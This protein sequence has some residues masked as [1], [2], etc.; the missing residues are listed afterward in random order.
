[1]IVNL[2]V[3]IIKDPKN[4]RLHENQNLDITIKSFVF[5]NKKGDKDGF[6]RYIPFKDI[7]ADL[8]FVQNTTSCFKIKDIGVCL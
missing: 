5:R 3:G 8:N 1:M 2:D 4:I 6:L 7:A